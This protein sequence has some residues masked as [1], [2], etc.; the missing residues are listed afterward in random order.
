MKI[1]P[2]SFDTR[3]FSTLTTVFGHLEDVGSLKNTRYE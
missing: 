3:R 1:L 2:P